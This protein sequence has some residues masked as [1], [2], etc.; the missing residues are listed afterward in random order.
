MIQEFDHARRLAPANPNVRSMQAYTPGQ[1]PQGGGWVKLNTNENPYPPS[2]AVGEAIRPEIDRLP[3]YPVP[4]ARPLREALASGLGVTPEMVIVGNGSDDLLNLLVRV[5][6]GTNVVGWTW[7]SY[8]LYPVL[9]AMQ[10]CATTVVPFGETMTLPVQSILEC[11][12]GLFFLTTPN[13]PTGAAF[14]AAEL[15]R[16]AA[17]MPGMVVFDEAYA[18]FAESNCLELVSRYANAAVVRTFS[19]SHSLAGLR[20][21]YAVAHPEVVALLDRVRDSYNVDR[22]AQA[23]ALAAWA[24]RE[25]NEQVVGRIKETR[26]KFLEALDGLGWHT[27][28]SQAN[29]VFTRPESVHRPWSQETAASLHRHLAGQKIL[30]RYF[31]GD[32]FWGSFLRISIGTDRDMEMVKEAIQQW[33]RQDRPQ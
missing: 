26:R 22:L 19:K 33:M 16:L 14:D 20:V 17:N 12:A 30:V 18:A 11:G 6:G 31:P 4:D 27:Y 32:A 3:L 7:P 21:G 25:Y 8:S 23:G 13:A 1:Q 28:R 24:D 5:Y 29:F 15:E 2:P 9:S 10:G